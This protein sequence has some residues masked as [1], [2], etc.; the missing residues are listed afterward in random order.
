MSLVLNLCFSHFCASAPAGTLEFSVAMLPRLLSRGRNRS[1]DDC[2]P[3]LFAIFPANHAQV[4][5]NRDDRVADKNCDARGPGKALDAR[6]PDM[7]SKA[8]RLKHT[9]Q[10]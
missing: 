4:N 9:A 6:P 1:G 2:V 3:R 5:G 7:I 10:T 8:Q